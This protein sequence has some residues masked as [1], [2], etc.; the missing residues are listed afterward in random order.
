[1]AWLVLVIKL[2]RSVGFKT[3]S[4]LQVF[5]LISGMKVSYLSEKLLSTL[6]PWGDALH[7]ISSAW[8]QELEEQIAPAKGD[9]R[10]ASS[11]VKA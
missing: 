3:S 10:D 8:A 7:S 4:L 6:V 11:G 1:M 5:Q 2:T 9:S